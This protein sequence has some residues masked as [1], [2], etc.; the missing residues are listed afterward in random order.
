MKTVFR[1]LS[2]L[3]CPFLLF[4]CAPATPSS[5]K[6]DTR[7]PL[8]PYVHFS[9]DDVEYCFN[10]LKNNAYTSIWDEPFLASLKKAHDTYG[11]KISL[12]VWKDV[13]HDQPTTYAAE[14]QACSDWLKIGIHSD[15]AGNFADADYERGKTAWEHFVADV[16]AMTGTYDSID[17]MPRLHNFA[18][19]ADALRGMQEASHGALGFLAADDSGVSYSLGEDATLWLQFCDYFTDENGMAYL[20]TDVRCE[21]H[22]TQVFSEVLKAKFDSALDEET[23]ILFTHEPWVYDGVTVNDRISWVDDVARYFNEKQIPFAFP[24]EFIYPATDVSE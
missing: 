1:L 14:W 21:R 8:S 22:R 2:F 13:L 6:Q 15:G 9:F 4:G 18:G 23:Y 19:S 17:R 10:N 11:V 20:T 24:Q 5:G 3:L 16:Y 7:V 12:Y